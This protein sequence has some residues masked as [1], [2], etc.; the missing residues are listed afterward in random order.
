MLDFRS[1]EKQP[2]QLTTW[3]DGTD[4]DFLFGTA[5]HP[6]LALGAYPLFFC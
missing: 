2:C 5:R 6:V 4:P 3:I 1:G